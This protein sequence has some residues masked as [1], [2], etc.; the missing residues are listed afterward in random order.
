MVS[1]EEI[2]QQLYEQ[3]EKTIKGLEFGMELSAIDRAVILGSTIDQF[4]QLVATEKALD[5]EE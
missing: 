2:V 1:A 3:I 5:S 4:A